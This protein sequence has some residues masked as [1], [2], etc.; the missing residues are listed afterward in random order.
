MGSCS[1]K[2]HKQRTH[3]SR[4]GLRSC[5]GGSG[6]FLAGGDTAALEGLFSR[7]CLTRAMVPCSW[8]AILWDA[9][10]E[11]WGQEVGCVLGL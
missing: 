2:G 11:K 3:G 7:L 8:L 10:K 9:C 5:S 6:V 1:C 4:L